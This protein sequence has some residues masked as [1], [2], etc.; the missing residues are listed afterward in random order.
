M[1]PIRGPMVTYARAATMI[2]IVALLLTLALRTG[3]ASAADS[4]RVNLVV[5]A[6]CEA[7]GN[8]FT[9]LKD[10]TVVIDDKPFRVT[11]T[12]HMTELARGA[13]RVGIRLAG[14]NKAVLIGVWTE[15]ASRHVYS[16]EAS[17]YSTVPVT[18]AFENWILRVRICPGTVEG[19][20]TG[21]PEPAGI[22][23]PLTGAA[24]GTLNERQHSAAPANG[25]G[26]DTLSRLHYGQDIAGGADYAVTDLPEPRP[27][28]CQAACAADSRCQSF[29]FVQP[30]TDNYPRPRCWLNS[31]PGHFVPSAAAVSGVKG[32]ASVTERAGAVSASGSTKPALPAGA[33]LFVGTWYGP[34]ES[35]IYEKDGR[36]YVKSQSGTVSGC[37]VNVNRFARQILA[38]DWSL[39][40]TLSD[41]A[42]TLRWTNGISWSRQPGADTSSAAG[43]P[44]FAR[45]VR[46]QNTQFQDASTFFSDANDSDIVDGGEYARTRVGL[47]EV[48]KT[49]CAQDRRCRSFV[50]VEPDPKDGIYAAGYCRLNERTGRLVPGEHMSSGVK[51]WH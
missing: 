7:Q 26:G 51:N 45:D 38:R 30:G 49:Q 34:K 10:A 41:D 11:G 28:L 23:E 32:G 48:C 15:G 35:S 4:G 14:E 24:T 42:Q 13:H 9:L 27:E 46:S 47:L 50:F 39:V 8:G 5:A 3:Q 37:T 22:R 44:P 1:R 2:Q 31:R 36:L 12:N 18:S 40:G 20:P 33:S 25:T 16:A 21:T 43:I 19:L 6:G 29:A 17:G